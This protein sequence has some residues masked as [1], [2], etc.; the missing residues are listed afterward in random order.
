MQWAKAQ[1]GDKSAVAED[2][3][4]GVIFLQHSIDAK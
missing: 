2:I 4:D 3:S 1:I